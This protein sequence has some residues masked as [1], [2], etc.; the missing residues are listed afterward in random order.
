V[1]AL[2]SERLI[3][4]VPHEVVVDAVPSD[5]GDRLRRAVSAMTRSWAVALRR[6]VEAAG[7]A[8][9][10]VQMVSQM[11]G[12]MESQLRETRRARATLTSCLVRRTSGMACGCG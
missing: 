12:W 11:S 4:L 7:R 6:R 10:S 9:L 8:W 1:E 5:L 3:E 2:G